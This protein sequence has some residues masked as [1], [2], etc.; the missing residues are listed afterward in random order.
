V[1]LYFP[2]SHESINFAK[3]SCWG[4][5]AGEDAFVNADTTSCFDL[6]KLHSNYGSA[7]T[8]ANNDRIDR[9]FAHEF[10]H[11]LHKAWR[12]KHGLELKSPFEYALWECLT[13]GLEITARFL[14]N[15]YW[16]AGN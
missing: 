4:N 15:G 3:D 11:L 7:S 10:T 5:L 6:S 13:E 9:F 14:R 2:L 1:A 16:Q 12:K 8:T